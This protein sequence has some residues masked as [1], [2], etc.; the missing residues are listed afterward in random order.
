MSAL[1]NLDA[2]AVNNLKEVLDDV[3]AA[4]TIGTLNIYLVSCRKGSIVI[5]HDDK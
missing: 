2:T 5:Q 3:K 1:N 4:T